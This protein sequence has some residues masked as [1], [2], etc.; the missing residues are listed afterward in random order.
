MPTSVNCSMSAGERSRE[1]S[2][3]F[4]VALICDVGEVSRDLQQHALVLGNRDHALLADAF[5]EKADFDAI[6]GKRWEAYKP[7]VARLGGSRGAAW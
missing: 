6:Y 4:L 2:Q 5:V 3:C 7:L 1:G